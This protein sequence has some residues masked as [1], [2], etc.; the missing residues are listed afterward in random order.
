MQQAYLIKIKNKNQMDRRTALKNLSLSLGYV[1]SAPTL[2]NMLS[3]CTANPVTWQP[4]FFNEPERNLVIH[5]V[6]I[7]IPS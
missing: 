2:M 7:I 4:V 1:V 3:S 6:D 5:L